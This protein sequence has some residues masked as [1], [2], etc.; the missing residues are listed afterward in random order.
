MD[1]LSLSRIAAILTLDATLIQLWTHYFFRWKQNIFIWFLVSSTPP[2][3]FPICFSCCLLFFFLLFLSSPLKRQ[4]TKP[5]GNYLK[6]RINCF[7]GINCRSRL[8][9][10]QCDTNHSASYKLVWNLWPFNLATQ[11]IELHLISVHKYSGYFLILTL[12]IIL[13]INKT[14][15]MYF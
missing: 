1:T 2:P 9:F 10:D 15:Y 11:E 7:V 5:F 12:N 6:W 13:K 3:H 8:A 4:A 14:V